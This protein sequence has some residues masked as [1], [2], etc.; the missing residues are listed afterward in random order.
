[1][2]HEV[3]DVGSFR[4]ALSRVSKH[5]GTTVGSFMYDIDVLAGKHL[6]SPSA[7][8]TWVGEPDRNAYHI[9]R[10]TPPLQ[11]VYDECIRMR[12]GAKLVTAA[13]GAPAPF[14]QHNGVLSDNCTNV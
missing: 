14:L 4:T 7:I 6:F 11:A 1:M 5:K 8:A 10:T 9:T 2:S 12:H 13:Q 3:G